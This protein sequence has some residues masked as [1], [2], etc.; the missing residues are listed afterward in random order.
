M[1]RVKTP[2]VGGKKGTRKNPGFNKK[3]LT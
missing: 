1:L 2:F 3:I